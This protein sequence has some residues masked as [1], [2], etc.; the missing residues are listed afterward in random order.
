MLKRAN[1]LSD[2]KCVNENGCRRINIFGMGYTGFSLP[3]HDYS[4]VFGSVEENRLDSSDLDVAASFVVYDED[5]EE[6]AHYFYNLGR[7][8]G[9]EEGMSEK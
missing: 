2:F 5:L 7:E 1:N 3:V 4:G 9:V 8:H 6:L